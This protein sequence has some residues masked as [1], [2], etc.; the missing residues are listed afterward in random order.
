MD[1]TGKAQDSNY[2]ER[3]YLYVRGKPFRALVRFDLSRIPDKSTIVSASFGLYKWYGIGCSG[4]TY[5]AHRVTSSWTEMGV[6]WKKRDGVNYWESWGGDVSREDAA[7]VALPDGEGW[8]RWD[9]KAMVQG[10]VSGSHENHG[11]LIKD[12]NE[13]GD[14]NRYSVFWSREYTGDPS[15]QPRLVVEYMTTSSAHG[16]KGW[17]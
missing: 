4:R 10:W 6:T 8:V 5:A 1:S 14:V 16:E 15:L 13:D 2:G 17:E 11:L 7:S 12:K 3:A 9:V